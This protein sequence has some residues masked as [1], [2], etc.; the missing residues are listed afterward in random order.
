MKNLHVTEQNVSSTF[1]YGTLG[2]NLAQPNQR[3]TVDSSRT[4][5]RAGKDALWKEQNALISKTFLQPL[6][7]WAENT[8][9]SKSL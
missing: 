3:K 1:C 2:Q 6:V 9:R 8:G 7:S 5:P 4:R